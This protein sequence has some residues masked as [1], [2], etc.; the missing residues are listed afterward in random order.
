MNFEEKMD[1]KEELR[2]EIE[3]LLEE[4]ELEKSFDENSD[5]L[6]FLYWQ[7]YDLQNKLYDLEK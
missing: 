2:K 5:D 3:N 4:I 6:S 7:L 1:K